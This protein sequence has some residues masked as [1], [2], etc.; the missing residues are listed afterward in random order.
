M[1]QFYAYA[2]E[3]QSFTWPNGAIGFRPCSGPFDTLGPY[4]KVH[5]CP[6]GDTGLTRTCY[7]TSHADT[8]FSIPA[9]TR[10]RGKYIGGYF[11][12]ND[13]GIKFNVLDRYKD[14]LMEAINGASVKK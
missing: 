11:S 12:Q 9:C 1:Q 14:R 8:F 10:V 2:A 7:A 3:S 13:D 4:A 6:I 5:N